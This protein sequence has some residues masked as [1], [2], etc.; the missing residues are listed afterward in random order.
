MVDIYIVPNNVNLTKIIELKW[1]RNYTAW[2]GR[3]KLTQ[4][5]SFVMVVIK[6]ENKY[7]AVMLM[8]ILMKAM[9]TMMIW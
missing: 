4:T 3:K 9:M 8:M 2:N 6:H 1:V 5:K 7:F